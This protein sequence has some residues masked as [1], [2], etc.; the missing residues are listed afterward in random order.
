MVSYDTWITF[1]SSHTAPI[2]TTRSCYID[3]AININIASWLFKGFLYDAASLSNIYSG[4]SLCFLHSFVYIDQ[5]FSSQT[6]LDDKFQHNGRYKFQYHGLYFYFPSSINVKTS[7]LWVA[8]TTWKL[9]VQLLFFLSHANFISLFY[10]CLLCFYG[11]CT[12]YIFFNTCISLF[13]LF[14]YITMISDQK[15]S[16][17]WLQYNW[18][19]TLGFCGIA[20]MLCL[21][22]QVCFQLYRRC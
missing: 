16:R 20:E 9:Q 11:F 13:Y 4:S 7:K 12:F 6:V 14:S 15:E 18:M 22:T 17:A 10:S 3:A 19:Q 21:R 1:P 2:Y 8:L 5:I